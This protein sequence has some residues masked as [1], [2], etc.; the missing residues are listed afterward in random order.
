MGF[1]LIEFKKQRRIKRLS[2]ILLFWG[3]LAIFILDATTTFPT[4][5]RGKYA[6]GWLI[7][8]A[9][10]AVLWII[11]KRLPLEQTIE[12]SKYCHGELKVTD[13]T[14]ELN[15]TIGT[16]ERILGALE[17]KGYAKPED[18]GDVRVWIFPEVKVSIQER[19]QR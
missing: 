9:I 11:S 14:S 12:V 5:I 17:R 6:V 18:R 7:I 10:G 13:I 8:V 4:P 19:Q 15:V 16:A 2:G 3:A 1:S